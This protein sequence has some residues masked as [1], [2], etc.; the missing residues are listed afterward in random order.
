[1]GVDDADGDVLI[2]YVGMHL[3][4]R[5]QREERAEACQIDDLAVEGHTG[6]HTDLIGLGDA[7]V[8]K[9][10]RIFFLELADLAAGADVGAGDDD[11]LVAL[12]DLRQLLDVHFTRG[13]RLDEV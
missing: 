7:G 6:G 4:E 5:A 1:M 2:G 9:A 8:D 3:I 10:V 12:G 13:E 11:A